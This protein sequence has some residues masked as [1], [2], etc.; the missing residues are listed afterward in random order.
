MV[1]ILI[2]LLLIINLNAKDLIKLHVNKNHTFL[3]FVESLS[4]ASYV[5][6]VPKRIYLSKYKNDIAKF[7]ELHKQISK[8]RIKKH[9]NT[10]NLLKAL[11]FESLRYKTFKEFESKIKSFEVGID[12]K[13]LDK[14]F[15]YLNKLYPR[16]EKILWNKTHKGLL[17][18]KNKL[19][20]L[21]KMKKFNQMIENVLKFYDVK[22]SEIGVM[23]VAF[24]PISYGSNINAYSMGN[25][26]SIGIF[27][28]KSQNLNWMLSSTILH[29]L[30]HSIY[31]KSKFVQQNFLNIK[32]Q[33][34]NRTIN[35]VFATAI[36]AGWGYNKLTKKYPLRL[37]YNNKVYDKYAKIIYPEIKKYI[38][39]GRVIDKEFATYIKGLL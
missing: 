24:Y 19:K 9:P 30:A 38:D 32:D 20:K 27:V 1:R 21:M 3:T 2:L 34:R 18:R 22:K 10:N 29:E 6:K 7:V 39:S 35:E 15:R 8:T 16:F 25:I 13:S 26:E 12:T 4:D 17:Y 28:G 5:S 33:K 23:D 36:G 11:Y 14:Y 37:W 31:R